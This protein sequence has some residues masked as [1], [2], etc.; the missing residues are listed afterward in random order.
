LLFALMLPL[1]CASGMGQ[2]EQRS[3]LLES[4]VKELESANRH[5]QIR[6]DAY[7][8]SLTLVE[9]EVAAV[10]NQLKAPSK[11][12][13]LEVVRIAPGRSHEESVYASTLNTPSLRVETLEADFGN[14]DDE[15]YEDIVVSQDMI[16]HYVRTGAGSSA[17]PVKSTTTKREALPDVV[18][19]E[20]LPVAGGSA[21]PSPSAST[22]PYKEGLKYYRQEQFAEAIEM[23]QSY[24][25]SNPPEDYIDNALYWLGE[26]YYGLGEYAE[27]AKHFHRI[28]QDYP[29]ANKVP[30]A[31]LKVGL[32]YQRLGK[33]DSAKEVMFYLIQAY[34]G[35]DAARMAQERVDDNAS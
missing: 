35:S 25:G 8:A 6:L 4:R 24:L 10:S 30:D 1:G 11:D 34:P 12:R 9:D 5:L 31:L 33:P 14:A 32:T 20:R 2:L 27:A 26:C 7:E 29:N 23:F 17:R 13:A 21:T 15:G 16:D 19:G 22:D 18:H 28:V 3:T